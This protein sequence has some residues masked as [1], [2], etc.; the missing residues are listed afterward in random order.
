M[1]FS[2]KY[3]PLWTENYRYAILTGGRGSAKSF[4][5]QTF[6]RDLT[7]QAGHKIAVTRYTMT[8]AEKSVIPEFTTKIEAEGLEDDFNLVGRT[9]EN[10][11]SGSE[12]YFMGLKTSSGV[13]TASLK[14]IEGLTTW[15][16]EEA[17]ELVDDGTETQACTFD[18]IDDSIRM[19][20]RDLRTILV[21]NPSTEDS[22]LYQRFFKERGVPVDFNGVKDGVLY[23]YTTYKDNIRNLHPSFVEKAERTRLHNPARYEHIYLGKPL[24]ENEGALWKASTMIAPYRVDDWPGE[25]RR[26]VVALDPSGSANGSG[27]EAGIITC[28]EDYNGHFYVMRDS[29]AHLSPIDWARVAIGDYKD[30]KADALIAEKNMGW[31]LVDQTLST[32]DDSIPVKGV[33]AK[34]GKILRAEPVSAL[35]SEG[36]VHHVG[37][38]PELEA[39]MC[40]YTGD[41]SQKSPNRLDSLVY[42]LMDLGIE[43]NGSVAVSFV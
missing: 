30:F 37:H 18:K 42:A 24:A 29:S 40:T 3:K 6:L 10:V 32:V 36:R 4:T 2:E 12:L 15:L 7:Y 25:L 41:P 28:G 22:F 38:F 11:T 20:G 16:M 23:I 43:K 35:Y 31:S 39:E 9:Y 27:D 8:S 34:R 33:V 14:S 13:Q 5:T 17:E 1:I 21:W 19:R 26:I